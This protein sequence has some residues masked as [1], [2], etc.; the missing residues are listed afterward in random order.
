MSMPDM[1]RLNK[2]CLICGQAGGD[3]A[4][5]HA[6]PK[7]LEKH[8]PA[9]RRREYR[10]AFRGSRDQ[11]RRADDS[12]P[13]RRSRR[14]MPIGPY[15]FEVRGLCHDCHHGILNPR[16]ENPIQPLLGGLLEG[17]TPTL[18]YGDQARLATWSWKTAAMFNRTEDAEA[19]AVSPAEWRWLHDHARP[20]RGARVWVGAWA[21]DPIPW[22]LSATSA[23]P[24]V[25]GVPADAPNT[26]LFFFAIK[27][28]FFAVWGTSAAH[29]LDRHGT[30][31]EPRGR[32]G[33]RLRQ[34]WPVAPGASFMWP[35][36]P[37]LDD[38]DFD[39][40]Y[41]GVQSFM[42]TLY[43]DIAVREGRP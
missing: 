17:E 30:E 18:R 8:A 32:L 21:G 29:L 36:G 6:W 2:P 28:V 10:G 13:P 23:Q 40:L 4:R 27:S 24:E 12:S 39:A 37:P 35:P 42:R 33:A 9:P 3:E 16:I 25:P 22:W 31:F 1:A 41:H 20:P 19:H 5:E 38:Q 11:P 34:I 15:N 26:Y 14:V 7:W 43:M